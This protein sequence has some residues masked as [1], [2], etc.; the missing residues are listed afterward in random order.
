MVWLVRRGIAPVVSLLLGFV[1]TGCA[2]PASF[3]DVRPTRELQWPGPTAGPKIVWVK[4]INGY[5]DVGI[6]K[7]FW[8]RTLEFFSGSE[9]RTIIRPHGVLLDSSERLFIADPGNGVVHCM[10]LR[11]SRYTIIGGESDSPLRSPI[12]LTEDSL[13][14]IY[15]TD[16]KAKTVFRHDPADGSLKPFLS[17]TVTR[18]T[19]IAFNRNN[20]LVYIVDTAGQQVIVTD[21][22]GREQFRFG[23]SGESA[24]QFNYPTD[25]AVDKLSQVLITDALN[26]RI[27]T[28]SP[29]GV[30]LGTFGAA[31]D[32]TGY[33]KRPKGLAVDSDGHIYV[34][35]SLRDAVQIFDGS[36]Q[37]LQS[38]GRQGNGDGEF[39]MPSGIFIDKRNFIY[40]A[41]TYNQRV[42]VFRYEA[43]TAALPVKV[44][45]GA[46]LPGK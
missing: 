33:L 5:Q 38:F 6:T 35:D 7:G 42:Q 40:V 46:T 23:S 44:E 41:D 17:G 18:P 22:E 34:V 3:Q 31:G 27:R 30:Q 9:D 14:R 45:P 2:A 32:G 8:K 20:G 25:I 37:L 43:G 26:Y 1:L 13:G 29:Q 39:W 28:F 12:G 16:S 19:G 36:G 24:G 15:I 10:D 11:K 21:V 4:T